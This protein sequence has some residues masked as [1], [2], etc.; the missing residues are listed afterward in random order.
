MNIVECEIPSQSALASGPA[1]YFQDAWRA[2][3]SKDALGVVDIFQAVLG[4]RLLWMKLLLVTRNWAVK[5]FGLKTAMAREIFDPPVLQSYSVGDKIGSW[6]I[7]LLNE[8]ELVAGRDN[9]HLDFRVSVMKVLS[10]LPAVVISTVCH[11][12]NPGGRAYLRVIKPF[13]RFGVRAMLRNAV[14]DGRL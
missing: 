1:A 7:Y 6:P 10:P 8:T 4:H 14:R 11:V 2:P 13:H 3:L 9:S 12:H 5:P